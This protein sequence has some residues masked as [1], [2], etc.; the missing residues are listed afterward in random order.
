[1]SH[2]VPS[3]ILLQGRASWD[4][5]RVA[6]LSRVTC[7]RVTLYIYIF[8]P[9]LSPK[10]VS[11]SNFLLEESPMCR[12][13]VVANVWMYVK[14]ESKFAPRPTTLGND[15]LQEKCRGW[16]QCSIPPRLLLVPRQRQEAIE[17]T[18]E[19]LHVQRI[20]F[21]HLSSVT[22]SIYHID[23][24]GKEWKFLQVSPFITTSIFPIYYDV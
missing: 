18:H 22:C 24:W 8:P 14:R 5:A 6:F 20:R 17:A 19:N 21:S 16:N 2:L 3:I 12:V 23:Y 9:C 7:K 13:I 1:M 4:I 10:M 11:T 15:P